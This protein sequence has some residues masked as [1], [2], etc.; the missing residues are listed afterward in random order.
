MPRNLNR[1]SLIVLLLVVLVLGA[2]IG[3][4]HHSANC[5]A[6]SFAT[7]PA[8]A[9]AQAAQLVALLEGGPCP[10]NGPVAFAL[11]DSSGA[12]MDVLDPLADPDGG[13][14]GVYQSPAP[15]RSPV[16]ATRYQLVLGRSEDLLH[17]QRLRVLDPNG[18]TMGTLQ[19]IPGTHGFL[20]AYEKAPAQVGHYVRLCYYPTRE[21][22]LG[23][24]PSACRDLPRTMS[25]LNDGT[26]SLLAIRWRGGLNRSLIRLGFHY[27]LAA[28]KAGG[29]DREAV[30]YLS[31]FRRFSA[32][33]DR[34][35]DTALTRA[36]FPG[37]HGDER[38]FTFA[39]RT[40]RVY[41][42]NTSA[43][44]FDSWFSVLYSPR[45]GKVYPL[46]FRTPAGVLPRSFGNPVVEVL[47]APSGRGRVLAMTLFV[48]SAGP[49]AP[50]AGEL[51]FYRTL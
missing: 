25:A 1:R 30:G 19:T 45:D 11:R 24:R 13:Y 15:G 12:P 39:G 51:L 31:G 14:L 50:L 4:R 29:P 22:L 42:A 20:L 38:R 49:A 36:G 41:E 43:S 3:A 10:Q 37:S 7:V 33:A 35:V 16:D 6:R 9:G 32:V 17:W 21:D 40:W 2:A 46:A 44:A 27:E 23:A 48:F 18:A 47:P 26:P 28:G 8:G 5:A 34:R